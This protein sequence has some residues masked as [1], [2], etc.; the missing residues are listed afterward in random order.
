MATNLSM[1]NCFCFKQQQKRDKT[2]L[3]QSGHYFKISISDGLFP[4][5]RLQAR[6]LC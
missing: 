2:C 4:K 3:I 6:N 5:K 1:P